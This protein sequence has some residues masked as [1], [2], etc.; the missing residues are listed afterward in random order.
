MLCSHGEVR[1]PYEEVSGFPSAAAV[2][3]SLSG[4]TMALLVLILCT[5]VLCSPDTVLRLQLFLS[6]PLEFLS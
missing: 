3:M 5:L 2:Q 1:I 4:A 6:L